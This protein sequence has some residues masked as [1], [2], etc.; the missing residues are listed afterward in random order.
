MKKSFKTML[1]VTLLEIMLVLAI[2]AMVI[3]MSIRYYQSANA[4]QQVNTASSM[5]TAIVVAADGLAQASGS[6]ATGGVSDTTVAPLLPNNSNA[7]PWG[8]TAKITSPAGATTFVTT[9]DKVPANVC[10]LL[11]AKF[12][13]TDKHFT[14][15]NT[16]KASAVG[17]VT[18]TYNSNP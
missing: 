9:F 6:Y 3:V 14:S 13:G 4:S 11:A 5:M 16:C 1:G 18:I 10:P 17:T 2:A 8:G 15:A 12:N 7:T